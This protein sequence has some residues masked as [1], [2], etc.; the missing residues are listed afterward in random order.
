MKKNLVVK[1]VSV[2]DAYFLNFQKKHKNAYSFI[3][4]LP[5]L[6]NE[7]WKCTKTITESEVIQKKCVSQ[8]NEF[9]YQYLNKWLY[10]AITIKQ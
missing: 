5:H 4:V 7:K 10:V 6:C 3:K 2:T 9:E 8:T 1:Y